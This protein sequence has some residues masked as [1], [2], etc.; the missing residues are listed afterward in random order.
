MQGFTFKAFQLLY[1]PPV[2]T[3]ENYA[4]LHN[5][6]ACNM[7]IKINSGYFPKPTGLHEMYSRKSTPSLQKKKNS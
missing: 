5:I 6:Y 7:L 1:V 2:L 4:F 3:F